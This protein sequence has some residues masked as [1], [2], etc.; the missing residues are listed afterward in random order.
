M[1]ITNCVDTK[2]ELVLSRGDG[3]VTTS[4]LQRYME[5]VLSNPE[6]RSGFK[7]L[8][9]FRTV[10]E[11][12]LS[13]RE[14]DTGIQAALEDGRVNDTNTAM[15]GSDANTEVLSKLC[16][17]L[18]ASLPANVRLFGDL[19]EARTWLGLSPEQGHWRDPRKAASNKVRI[20]TGIHELRGQLINISRS[21][22]LLKCPTYQPFK[23]RTLKIEIQRQGASDVDLAGTVVRVTQNT[24]ATQFQ[25][26]TDE[27]AKRIDELP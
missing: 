5:T 8:M 13:D 16:K 26:V 25:S 4:D 3:V 19:P 12:R 20:R 17:L 21:G 10:T 7:G 24:F 6:V 2:A 15:V 11:V 18:E 22:A 14:I 27:V 1:A 23:G 9:D